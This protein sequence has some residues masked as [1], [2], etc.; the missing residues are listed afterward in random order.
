MPLN[1]AQGYFP[2][3]LTEKEQR[4]AERA[5]Y[6]LAESPPNPMTPD[7]LTYEDR[8]RMR[9][10]LEQLDQ[11]EAAGTKE[12]D[13]NKP[14]TQAYVYREYPYL[15]YDHENKRTRPAHNSDERERMRAEGWSEDPL[16]P[17]APPEIPLTVK[18]LAE[19]EEI[20]SRLTKK[21]KT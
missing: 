12:F 14:P 18:E 16:P 2:S 10:L 3:N 21:R 5:I 4:E 19:A 11:K 7:T 1:E 6:G 15:M 9:R 20:D 17:E 13:L 8:V